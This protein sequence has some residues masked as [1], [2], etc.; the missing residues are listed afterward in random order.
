MYARE[1][2]LPLKEE[3]FKKGELSAFEYAKFIN[4]TNGGS[5][6]DS[7]VISEFFDT[8]CKRAKEV[9]GTEIS[10]SFSSF[11][12]KLKFMQTV[13]PVDLVRMYDTIAHHKAIAELKGSEGTNSVSGNYPRRIAISDKLENDYIGNCYH[14][15]D[16]TLHYE[17]LA[18][19]TFEHEIGHLDDHFKNGVSQHYSFLD[20]LTDKEKSTY[21]EFERT[22]REQYR[23]WAKHHA[24]IKGLS[25]N[26]FHFPN[27]YD[28]KNRT[29]V[30]LRSAFDIFASVNHASAG[31][32]TISEVLLC[33][34]RPIIDKLVKFNDDIINQISSGAYHRSVPKEVKAEAFA[35]RAEGN[36]VKPDYLL[37]ITEELE[38]QLAKL[39][40]PTPK[41]YTIL[42]KDYFSIP[43]PEVVP[44]PTPKATEQGLVRKLVTKFS[45]ALLKKLK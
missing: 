27:T 33:R 35:I 6:N 17:H 13:N 2:I 31:S 28:N 30:K 41:T 45:S 14:T 15:G 25:E 8:L 19:H 34:V 11:Y 38:A 9:L 23:F 1:N 4:F 21:E 12:E 10:L 18:D 24:D 43:I 29:L 16:I 22:F 42:P 36:P 39:G 7:R 40:M 37:P 44:V 20:I 32:C 5:L 3:A 26:S